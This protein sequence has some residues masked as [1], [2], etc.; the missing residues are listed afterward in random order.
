LVY[1]ALA[2]VAAGLTFLP[3]ARAWT[4]RRPAHPPGAGA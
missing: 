3:D 2:V 1:G 4:A